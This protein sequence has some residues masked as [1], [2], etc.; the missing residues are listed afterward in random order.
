MTTY[1][2]TSMARVV[3]EIPRENFD[4]MRALGASEVRTLWEVVILGTLDKAFE[5]LRQN[6]A[7]GWT[8]ITMVEGISRAEGG[9]GALILNQNKHFKL[10]AVFA[11]LFVI[12]LVGLVL[13]YL[14][15]ALTRIVCPYANLERMRR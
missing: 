4:H 13:D 7:I 5:V 15:G 10:D 11:V 14:V 1:F 12:L 8:M 9:I 6:F 3:I 2:V